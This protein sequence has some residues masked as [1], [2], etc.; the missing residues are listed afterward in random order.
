MRVLCEDRPCNAVLVCNLVGVHR[1]LN[2]ELELL[3]SGVPEIDLHDWKRH[4]RYVGLY[5][6]TGPKHPVVKWFWEVVEG[7][8]HEERARLLQFATG[9]SR[10]PA[11]GFKALEANGTA[12]LVVCCLPIVRLLSVINNTALE[13]LT[14]LRPLVFAL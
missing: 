12:V 11:Q 13:W 10:L 3:I 14:L 9:S 6:K 5:K 8:N 2:Q 4:S 7:F 1:R